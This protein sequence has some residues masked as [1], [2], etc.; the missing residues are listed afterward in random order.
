MLFDCR[1]KYAELTLI[2]GQNIHQHKINMKEY[3]M[4]ID[5]EKSSTTFPKKHMEILQKH[6]LRIDILRIVTQPPLSREGLRDDPKNVP[7]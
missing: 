5:T 4:N 6:K 2:Q 1:R 7:V 3:P